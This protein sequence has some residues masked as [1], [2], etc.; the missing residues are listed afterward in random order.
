MAVHGLG[1][2]ANAAPAAQVPLPAAEVG[3]DTRS[4]EE[5]IVNKTTGLMLAL[6]IAFGSSGT[7]A[8][9]AAAPREDLRQQMHSAT[10]PADIVRIADRLLAV[11]ER[12][13]AIA[14]AWD[15]RR[16]AAWTAQ[17]L[18]SNVMLLQR[19]AFVAGNAPG[20]RQDLRQAALGNAEAALRM[21]RRYQPG[22]NAATGDP[23]RYVGWLQLASQLGSD[24]ASYELALF[25]RREGQPSRAA[26]YETRAAQQGYVAPVAL[27]HV[28]K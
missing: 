15:T 9:E 6:L 4:T 11:E 23:H 22:D 18:R 14:D 17:L 28:R 10:W 16:K 25:F 27:D 3:S 8:N 21:A 2:R 5:V 20:E 24:N 7:L 1:H 13:D 26:V 12:D 19:S